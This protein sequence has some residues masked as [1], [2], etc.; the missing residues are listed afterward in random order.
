MC[1]FF[2]QLNNFVH[3]IQACSNN[4]SSLCPSSHC[5]GVNN[6]CYPKPVGGCPTTAVPTTTTTT[7]T[8]TTA[9]TTTTSLSELL[10]H[11]TSLYRTKIVVISVVVKRH[12]PRDKEP[13][14]NCF[15]CGIELRF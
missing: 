1:F 2:S 5:C 14:F 9:P 11:L 7:T 4:D 10:L 13:W 6:L 12:W 3:L 8:T 15:R